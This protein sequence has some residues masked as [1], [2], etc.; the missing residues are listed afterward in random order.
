MHK[1]RPPEASPS[2]SIDI[3]VVPGASRDRVVGMLGDAVKV[4]VSRPASQ[5]QANDAVRETLARA[6]GL[7]SA[8]VQIVRGHLQPRKTVQIDGLTRELVMRR[9][10]LRAD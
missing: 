9:L 5:G 10:G 3:K 7:R 1:S 6:L 8:Q 2:C 4:A